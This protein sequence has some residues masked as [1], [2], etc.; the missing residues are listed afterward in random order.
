MFTPSAAL[1]IEY[2]VANSGKSVIVVFVS[3]FITLGFGREF[4]LQRFKSIIMMGRGVNEIDW[5]NLS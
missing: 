3:S 5:Y 4:F 2:Y 1:V